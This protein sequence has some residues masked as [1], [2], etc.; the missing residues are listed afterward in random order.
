M[1]TK[2]FVPA[3]ITAA[4][5]SFGTLLGYDYFVGR[6]ASSANIINKND[7]NAFRFASN[8]GDVVGAPVDFT[9]AAKQ[10]VRSVVHIQT[11]KQGK[12]YIAQ[13]PFGWG[14]GRTFKT[15]DAQGAGSGVIISEDGY[16][17]T[18]NHVVA[19]ADEVTVTFNDRNTQIA[20]VVG[21]DPE[22]DIAL[23]KIEGKNLPAITFGNSEEVQL[24]QWVLAVGYPL[25]LDCTVTAGIVSAKGRSLGINKRQSN[26]PIESFIQTDAAVNP[27]NSGGA[28][29]NTQGQLIGINAAI[30]SP[31]GSYAGYSYAVPSNLARKVVTDLM[32]FGEVQRGYLGAELID[33]NKLSLE[34]AKALNIKESVFKNATGVYISNVIEGS[35]AAAAGIK[36][37]DV[38]T[39][40]NDVVT[41]NSSVLMEQIA[42]YRPNDK[43]N[44]TIDRDGS[45]KIVAVTLKSMS[46]D[47]ANDAK[48]RI[49]KEGTFLGASIKALSPAEARKLGLEG[50]VLI[51][52][53][54]DSKL[55]KISDI[56]PGF[57]IVSVNDQPIT[58]VKSLEAAV[59]KSDDIIRFG[60]RY[61][62][63]NG[64]YYYT[65]SL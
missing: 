20:K 42:L 14:G 59:K 30:A 5:T 16:I 31:T 62:N 29:V 33:L 47:V 9:H 63:Q 7:G 27:G 43:V 34:Q 25:N 10:S 53:T 2:N 61:T 52:D 40:I 39:A 15:P 13:D 4:L 3:V 11:V 28:L 23:L 56:R 55:S 18:S 37:G 21:I 49:I 65:F 1:N 32:K 64:V 58:D 46:K 38:I 12:T 44:V 24:G 54:R 17:I 6:S 36:S 41:P 45:S 50:G 60:G 26:S 35:G 19:G 48:N 8:S 57:I 22:T 51:T